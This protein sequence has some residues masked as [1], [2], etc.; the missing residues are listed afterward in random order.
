MKPAAAI[1]AGIVLGLLVV[2]TTA[3]HHDESH[4]GSHDDHGQDFS[5]SSWSTT[6]MNNGTGTACQE[7]YINCPGGYSGESSKLFL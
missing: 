2:F 3:D 6:E 1:V 5:T 7:G 4:N